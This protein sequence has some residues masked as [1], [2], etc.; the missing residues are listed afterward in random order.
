MPLHEGKDSG[1]F[2]EEGVSGMCIFHR[3]SFFSSILVERND[4]RILILFKSYLRNVSI[5]KH[6]K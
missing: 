5:S 3:N 4:T 2:S 1:E 6:I